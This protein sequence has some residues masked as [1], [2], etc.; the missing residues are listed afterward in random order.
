MALDL[1]DLLDP[2]Y[3][4][5]ECYETTVV[6]SAYC[7][8]WKEQDQEITVHIQKVGVRHI[9]HFPT[10]LRSSQS[11]ILTLNCDVQVDLY[12]TLADENSPFHITNC[13]NRHFQGA[14]Q[15]YDEKT[16]SER[17]YPAAIDYNL[18]TGTFRF[19]AV[20]NFA[21][22]Q[23]SHYANNIFEVGILPTT[24]IIDEEGLMRDEEGEPTEEPA[25]FP[26]IN[27]DY[28]EDRYEAPFIEPIPDPEEDP[29]I[30]TTSFFAPAYN[31]SW[32][33]GNSQLAYQATVGFAKKGNRGIVNI[34]PL[35][36]NYDI[37]GNAGYIMIEI[38]TGNIKRFFNGY[39]PSGELTRCRV[40]TY[41]KNRKDSVDNFQE[42]DA[43]VFYYDESLRI[44]PDYS[45]WKY[46]YTPAIDLGENQMGLINGLNFEFEI[47]PIEPS[48]SDLRA[49]VEILDVNDIP[50]TLETKNYTLQA[51]CI[52]WETPT[53][54]VQLTFNKDGNEGEIIF[55]EILSPVATSSEAPGVLGIACQTQI[56]EFFGQLPAG[57]LAS[58]TVHT[59]CPNHF[60]CESCFKDVTGVIYYHDG[61]LKIVP[62]VENY[63]YFFGTKDQ[64]FTYIDTTA[65][66]TGLA[67][68]ITVKF[69]I[70]ESAPVY[71]NY[72]EGKNTTVD[73]SKVPKVYSTWRRFKTG[74]SSWLLNL[75]KNNNYIIDDAN[76]WCKFGFSRKENEGSIIIPR[77]MGP[78]RQTS[79][80]Q[81]ICITGCDDFLSS[82]FGF[83]PNGKLGEVTASAYIYSK[84]G[85]S[86]IAT[87]TPNIKASFSYYKD[88][89]FMIHI[90]DSNYSKY[91]TFFGVESLVKTDEWGIT[92]E[93][94]VLTF[95][96][97][98]EE[99]GN[100][101]GT[102]I[103]YQPLSEVI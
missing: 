85:D 6:G 29:E 15:V 89:G 7:E 75:N 78:P 69:T 23:K 74:T 77:I 96:I 21:L 50:S 94:K 38:L 40:K 20:T 64:D 18:K 49:G 101:T 73:L 37:D 17:I 102:I 34:Q 42:C 90:D 92:S 24:I 91:K 80:G 60:F 83:V 63:H 61:R 100:Y 4:F 14:M 58:C 22:N 30:V 13:S 97:P 36:G 31:R 79:F 12:Y 10:F 27:M 32:V 67:Q 56:E 19:E 71:T 26:D 76:Q 11:G 65:I 70:P 16:E 41:L 52:A 88:R 3:G 55:P 46:F 9:I 66:D 62:D 45:Y 93:N 25:E 1:E 87:L 8:A 39:F 53:K 43:T 2:P 98:S 86:K 48:Y 84:T 35:I 47:Q 72:N 5:G 68:V 33:Y 99:P 95:N 28:E 59:F 82:F 57:K 103:S 81:P 54:D 51:T 44:T